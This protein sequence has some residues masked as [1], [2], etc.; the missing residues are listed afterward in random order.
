MVAD[1]VVTAL[2]V[3]VV[4]DGA[5]A[6]ARTA[7]SGEPPG[8]GVASARRACGRDSR[9]TSARAGGTPT[10]ASTAT[11]H[12]TTAAGAR[13]PA[14]ERCAICPQRHVTPVPATGTAPGA[15]LMVQLRA[16]AGRR[17][18]CVP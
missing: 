8:A 6:R 11:T 9:M 16:R 18:R 10:A 14:V 5:P 13:Q 2:A 4:T 1:V 3:P 7:T 15:R 17:R 12:P